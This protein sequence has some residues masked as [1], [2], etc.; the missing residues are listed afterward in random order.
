MAPTLIIN[1]SIGVSCMF[2]QNERFLVGK[3]TCQRSWSSTEYFCRNCQPR[4]TTTSG[5]ASPSLHHRIIGLHVKFAPNCVLCCPLSPFFEKHVFKDNFFF[6]QFNVITEDTEDQTYDL[7]VG[8]TTSDFCAFFHFNNCLSILM[9]NQK[10]LTRL[11]Q[12]IPA[13]KANGFWLK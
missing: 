2:I 3:K 9:G 11:S 8:G 1:P 7:W 13:L 6:C 5:G 4:T 12:G 10:D